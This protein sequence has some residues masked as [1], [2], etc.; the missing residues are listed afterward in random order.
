M[1]TEEEMVILSIIFSD[2]TVEQ[3]PHEKV[4]HELLFEIFR[5]SLQYEESIFIKESREKLLGEALVNLEKKNPRKEYEKRCENLKRYFA[6]FNYEYFFE[7]AQYEIS[8]SERD[9]IRII[10][11]ENS[12]Y[13]SHLK[14]IDLPPFVLYIKGLFP[15]DY[16]FNH[17]LAIIGSRKMEEKYGKKI[18]LKLGECLL[19]SAWYNISGLA[20][21]CDEYGHRGSMGATGAILGQGLSTPVFPRENIELAQDIL[22]SDGFLLSE[23]P[24]STPPSGHF[25]ILRDR[26][27]SGLTKGVIVVETS[28]NGGTLY[29]VKYALEQRKEVFVMDMEDIEELR[30]EEVVKG[31]I[32]L[33][34][35]E[36]SMGNINIPKKERKKIIGLKKVEDLAGYLDE[37]GKK[38][39]SE[40]FREKGQLVQKTLL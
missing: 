4:D 2:Y 34:N 1:Y 22:D 10:T 15:S 24:P 19:N 3:Y 7:K 36:I 12:K 39:F 28:I 35:P 27:Q 14:N 25:L 13:P 26:L 38:S 6:D 29:T 37:I 17:S 33:L 21:G 23:L 8:L 16:E 20:L 30:G 11:Y 31:N 18:A 9:G 5:L 40:Q 32:A